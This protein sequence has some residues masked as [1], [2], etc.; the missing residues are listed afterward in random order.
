MDVSEVADD[1]EE[2]VQSAELI[3]LPESGEEEKDFGDI[4]ES[5]VRGDA[6]TEEIEEHIVDWVNERV[7][8]PF[9]PESLEEKMFELI[10]SLLRKAAVEAARRIA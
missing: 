2:K 3:D 9:V 8:I 4:V 5:V 7:D 10:S 1:L 6:T